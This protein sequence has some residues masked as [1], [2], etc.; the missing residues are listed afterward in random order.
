MAKSEAEKAKAKAEKETAEAETA[1]A[2]AEKAKA[3]AETAEAKAKQEQIEA[4]AAKKAQADAEE[5]EAKAKAK[6]EAEQKIAA[7]K[8]LAEE[9]EKNEQEKRR[10]AM[11]KG[12]QDDQ[13]VL[14]CVSYK[15]GIGELTPE[16]LNIKWAG[17]SYKIPLDGKPMKGGTIPRWA[18]QKIILRAE[19]Y[20]T[21]KAV[22][23][24][25]EPKFD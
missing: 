5:A 17:K 12:E 24:I 19:R 1:K 9:N 2:Q 10:Q 22:L 4:E 21:A 23:E 8:R 3:E 7:D 18:A 13:V 25:A 15:A 20:W 11:F 14:K 16:V 6:A